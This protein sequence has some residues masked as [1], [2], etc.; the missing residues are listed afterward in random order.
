M[1]GG[2]S[3]IHGGTQQTGGLDADSEVADLMKKYKLLDQTELE[4]DISREDLLTGENIED[5]DEAVISKQKKREFEQPVQ[6]AGPDKHQYDFNQNEV[7]QQP[8]TYDPTK[9]PDDGSPKPKIFYQI[10]NS[11]NKDFGRILRTNSGASSVASY[12]E[13]GG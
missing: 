2:R 4:Q 12:E 13:I 1:V 7:V 5:E 6:H 8:A 3:T 10:L 11:K 9:K